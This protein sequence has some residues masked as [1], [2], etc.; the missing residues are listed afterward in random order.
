MQDASRFILRAL[1]LAALIT[2]SVGSQEA[3]GQVPGRNVGIGGQIGD[4]SGITLKVYE[5]PGF[6]YDFL[7]AWAFD[8]FFFFNA[9]GVFESPIRDSPLRY[10][11]GPGGLIGVREGRNNQLV[12]GF[13]G[14]FGINFYAE[15]FEV[16]LQ[17]TPRLHLVPGTDGEI[18]GGVGLRYY[19]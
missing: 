19:L 12:L 9:H 8:H 2:G 1:L 14:N 5:R 16:F 7:A 4:P 13:S 10:Y 15:R 3:S 18:G 6:A 11:L 17:V